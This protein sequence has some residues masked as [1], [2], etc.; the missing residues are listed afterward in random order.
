MIPF[1]RFPGSADGSVAVIFGIL[2]PALLGIAALGIEVGHWYSER[3]KLQIAAD[4]AAFSALMAYG[5]DKDLADAKA[6]GVARAK[7]SGFSGNVTQIQI[8][9]PSPDGTL[10]PNSSRVTIQASAPLF[11]SALFLDAASVDIGVTSYAT[12]AETTASA[13]CMLALKPNQSRAIVSAA[14]VQVDMQCEVASNSAAAD[15]IWAEG[16]A[17][18]TADC[19]TLPGEIASNGGGGV[20]LTDCPGGTYPRTTTEDYLSSTPFWGSSEVADTGYF[21]D[22]GIPQGR[23]GPGMPGGNILQPGKY[24]KQVEIAGNVILQPGVYYFTNGFRATNGAS[25]TGDGVTIYLDQTKVVDIAQSVAWDLKAPTSGPTKGMAIM[26]NPAVTGGTV[27]L[28]GVIGNVNGAV[29]F[30]NQTLQTESGPN[31][32][33]AL[34]T[35]IVASTIDIRGS[36]SIHNDCSDGGAA[37]ASGAK[38]VRLAQGPTA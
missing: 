24:G 30:P 8:E 13:P 27:R 20:T 38:K 29:Y 34:C 35:Q 9:I 19:A 2:L 21:A 11:L 31:L 16:T 6:V 3:D 25:I 12:M 32:A 22:Q 5:F 10:G 4:S 14:S 28:I 33:N 26:G 18:L 15:A 17:H 7:S 36:G 23:Y 37:A 1:R